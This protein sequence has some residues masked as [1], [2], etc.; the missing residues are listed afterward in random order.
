[1]SIRFQRNPGPGDLKPIEQ[2]LERGY[3]VAIS[4]GKTANEIQ[5]VK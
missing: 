4:P 5:E 3:L 2:N 1:L